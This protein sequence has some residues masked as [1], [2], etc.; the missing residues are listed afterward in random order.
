MATKQ[1]A[2]RYDIGAGS[3]TLPDIVSATGD[4]DDDFRPST[5][6]DES[7]HF[8]E[9]TV[10]DLPLR[11]SMSTPPQPRAATTTAIPRSGTRHRAVSA[12]P[13]APSL[14]ALPVSGAS[15][16]VT[17]DVPEGAR[18]S[19]VPHAKARPST[20]APFAVAVTGIAAAVGVALGNASLTWHFGA[21]E[22]VAPFGSAAPRAVAPALPVVL[23][24]SA[25]PHATASAKLEARSPPLTVPEVRY[26][27]LPIADKDAQSRSDTRNAATRRQRLKARAR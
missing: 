25:E 20:W 11:I 9:Q 5:L 26:E 8:N 3:A 16:A 2:T 7:A 10:P 1:R 13:P 23:A 24:R 15:E 18:P 14:A 4:W 27:D 22:S 19:F 6:T 12:P 21:S 17:P